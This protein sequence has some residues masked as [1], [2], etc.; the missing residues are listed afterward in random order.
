MAVFRGRVDGSSQQ[1]LFPS[2][3]DST[4]LGFRT[5]VQPN[6]VGA[7]H[8]PRPKAFFHGNFQASDPSFGS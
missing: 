4:F 1:R 7:P 3:F 8:Y 2:C 6:P 5:V